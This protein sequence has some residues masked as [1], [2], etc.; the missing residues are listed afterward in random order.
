MSQLTAIPA[1]IMRKLFP[2]NN[3]LQQPWIQDDDWFILHG[4]RKLKLRLA[5]LANLTQPHM[6]DGTMIL[7]PEITDG[8]LPDGTVFL[9]LTNTAQE[10]MRAA[11]FQV[12]LVTDLEQ[13]RQSL[14]PQVAAEGQTVH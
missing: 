6:N 2:D 13:A 11:G 1:S 5:E 4:S 12:E 10:K 9:R 7:H 14:S 8:I 3:V